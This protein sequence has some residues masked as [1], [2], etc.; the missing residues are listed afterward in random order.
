MRGTLKFYVEIHDTVPAFDGRN[1][2]RLKQVWSLPC[3]MEK[4][5][6]KTVEFVTKN[7]QLQ[8]VRV[9]FVPYATEISLNFTH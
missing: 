1:C 8:I 3:D 7:K 2:G 4:A 6:K 9:Q 5:D